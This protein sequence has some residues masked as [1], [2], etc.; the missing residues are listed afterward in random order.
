MDDFDLDIS[1]ATR[2][3][4]T[5]SQVLSPAGVTDVLLYAADRVGAAAE[6]LIPGAST[7]TPYP[8]QTHNPL[9]LYYDRMSAPVYRTRT[10]NGI[11]TR[12][13]VKPPQP[14]KSKFKSLKQQRYVMALIGKGKIPYRRTGTL[15]K[16]FTHSQPVVITPGLVQVSVGTNLSYAPYVVGQGTQSHYHQGNWPTLE[17]ALAS[18][19]GDLE[20]V[21][22]TAI[23]YD[24]KR[25][26]RNG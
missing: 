26:L 10:V 12:E 16:S 4:D 8:P 25:K 11:K 6:E 20:A 9:P 23:I 5:A 18:H 21:A 3:L 7:Q 15:G 1:A 22:V 19:Y 24:I 17:F 2:L 14:Y 13:M